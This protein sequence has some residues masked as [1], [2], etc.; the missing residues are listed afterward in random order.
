MHKL[1][2][3]SLSVETFEPSREDGVATRGTVQAHSWSRFGQQT[4]GGMS[5]DY[6]CVTLYD[7]TC[8]NVCA[9]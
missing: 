5:C 8:R 4:C 3:E 9:V 1:K 7:Y 2:L 6:A